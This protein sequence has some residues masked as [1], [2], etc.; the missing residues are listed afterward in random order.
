MPRIA[1]CSIDPRIVSGRYSPFSLGIRQ[2]HATIQT[3]P[4]LAEWDVLR[5]EDLSTDVD[6]WLERILAA[7]V[8]VVGL[9]C[10]VWSF[11]TFTA[12][13]THLRQRAPKLRIVMGGPCARPVMYELP[14]YRGLQRDVDAVVAGEGEWLM[15]PLLGQRAWEPAHLA[16]LPGVHVATRDGWL[17]GALPGADQ[18][19]DLLASAVLCNLVEFERTVTVERYRGCPMACTFCQWGDLTTPHRVFS[20]ERMQRELQAMKD[21]GT[22]SIQLVDAGLNLNARAFQNFAEAEAAVGL[23]RSATLHACVYPSHLTDE[24]LAFLKTC[25]RPILDLGVQTFTA[26][27]LEMMNRP[28]RIAR[29]ERVVADLKQV[30]EVQ[31][32]LILGLPGDNPESFKQS[33]LRLLELD[34]KVRVFHCLVLPDALMS[35]HRPEH[36]LRF[37]PETF[38]VTS[39]LGWS[40]D[41]LRQTRDW[42][43]GL[44][45]RVG[46]EYGSNMWAF[47]GAEDAAGALSPQFQPV[48]EIWRDVRDALAPVV[49]A[50]T[51]G[52]W[53]LEEVA[54]ARRSVRARVV[55]RE[56]DLQLDFVPVDEAKKSYR[57]AAGIA[58]SYRVLNQAPLIGNNLRQL[59][60]LLH[61]LLPAVAPHVRDQVALPPP[62][63]IKPY[64]HPREVGV[65]SPP[66]VAPPPLAPVPR[67]DAPPLA[68]F[69]A[70]WRSA[71]CMVLERLVPPD[72]CAEVAAVLDAE[73]VAAA[74]AEIAQ[75]WPSGFAERLRAS[76][77]AVVPFWDPSVPPDRPPVERLMR[78]GHQL[79]Q[80]PAVAQLLRRPD[81]VGSLQALLR[82]PRLV[83]CVLIDKVPGGS[84]QFGLHQDAWYLQV[85][86]ESVVSLQI[87]LD[88]ADQ[89]N[90]CLHLQPTATPDAVSGRAE[91]QP[92]GWRL[93]AGLEP[94]PTV[95]ALPV[96]MPRGT[97]LLYS[98]RSWHASF[99]NRSNRH[100]RVLVAQ[101]VEGDG[102]WLAAN[103]LSAP[104]GGF[105]PWP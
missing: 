25:Q 48:I 3:D 96:P 78:L 12:V 99:R 27:A 57:S 43:D 88:D 8:D 86:P 13:A 79:Q 29:F 21:H 36:K 77:H 55:A 84:V 82:S 30:A 54:Q 33:V 58:V 47:Y 22:P 85:E 40:E 23:L 74:A 63:V 38:L 102:Q 11:P 32:E 92:D 61:A 90:G 26:E 10:Y 46:G 98:G 41:E 44:C 66:D 37:D 70:A 59:D 1:L 20:A 91:L 73:V 93:D 105:P 89:E 87:A 51:A 4:R 69:L 9:S 60:A 103:W 100:R 42:L 16:S 72:V 35:R 52:A 19:L 14:R 68:V 95:K 17:S 80:V 64:E 50:A 65:P 94:P 81:V 5:L 45:A 101:F 67:L 15:A 39:C 49:T 18:P 2:L 104:A 83:D 56:L 28:F 53:A 7:R 75:P 6:H 76:A 24:H 31:P 62:S 97:V 34:C 71:H